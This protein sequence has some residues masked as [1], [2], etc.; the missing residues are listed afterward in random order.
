MSEIESKVE[1]PRKGGKQPGAPK[2]GG[3]KKGTPNKNSFLFRKALDDAN[4]NIIE[5]MIEQYE[6]L[7]DGEPKVAFLKTMLPYLYPALKEI[8]MPALPKKDPL[9]KTESKTSSAIL[10]KI[11]SSS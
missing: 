11:A 10:Q 4:F 7:D 2:T 3:R 9:E 6:L 8:E 5:E 1:S